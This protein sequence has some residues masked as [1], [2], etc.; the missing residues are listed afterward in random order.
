MRITI[1]GCGWLGMPLAQQLV[2]KGYIIFGSTTRTDKLALLQNK[3]IKAFLFDG[4]TNR[5]VPSEARDSEFL[6]LNFPPGKTSNYAEQVAYIL[7][8]MNV[9]TQVLFTSSTGVYE[10]LEGPVTEESPI[11]ED[12]AVTLAENMVRLSG[13]EFCI[14][15]LAG[16]IGGER[17]PVKYLSGRSVSDGNMV[18]NLVHRDDV[19]AG[20]EKILSGDRWNTVYNFV[21][22]EHPSKAAY[23]SEMAKKFGIIEPIFELSVKKGKCVSGKKMEKELGFIYGHPI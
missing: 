9:T 18:V 12:H 14:V 4:V 10:D 11:K 5:T 15:R 23:Y 7:D 17:H 13:K 22:P 20:I 19:I 6:I 16:L 2:E 3:G 1:I 8:K 21:Y